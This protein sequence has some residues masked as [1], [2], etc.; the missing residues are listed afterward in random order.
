MLKIFKFTDVLD[1][2]SAY[3]IAK[4]EKT[5]RQIL[6]KHTSLEVVLSEDVRD[7]D[8]FPDAVEF[9]SENGCGVWRSRLMP[10]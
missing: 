2:E 8:D 1:F 3:V 7:I 5:A 4:T 9:H 6:K 10:F